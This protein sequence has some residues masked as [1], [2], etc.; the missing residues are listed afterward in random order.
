MEDN[1]RK[2]G[3]QSVYTD[4]IAA[5]ICE[6]LAEGESLLEICASSE[7]PGESTVRAWVVD[8]LNDFAAKYL[9]ARDFGLD[10]ESDEIKALADNCRTGEKVERKEVGRQCSKCGGSLKWQRKGW[11]H[12][13]E[14]GTT[15]DQAWMCDGAEAERVYKDTVTVGDMVER[16]R[17]QIEAR[18]WRLS[19]MAPKR[20]GER[21]Q[22]ANDEENPVSVQLASLLTLEELTAIER[23][24]KAKEKGEEKK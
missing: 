2:R 23:R 11:K 10:H 12:V 4:G 7:M 5:E 15:T 20:Y 18:K 19:K 21:L 3:G 22:L 24:M 9:R 14:D 1:K 8:N 13:G 6:R 17:L 16:T